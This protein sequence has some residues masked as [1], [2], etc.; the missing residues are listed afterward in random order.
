MAGIGQSCS[1]QAIP[2][3]TY[4]V[5]ILYLYIKNRFVPIIFFCAAHELDMSD[6]L[7]ILGKTKALT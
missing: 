1:N 2:Q 7:H 3:K 6:R 4:D 5:L